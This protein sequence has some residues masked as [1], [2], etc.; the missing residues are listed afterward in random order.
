MSVPI[1]FQNASASLIRIMSIVYKDLDAELKLPPGTSKRFLKELAYQFQLVPI[2]DKDF[3]DSV[4]FD[5]EY[6]P[7]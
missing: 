3:E 2:V 6:R 5:L 4:R 1:K 7:N